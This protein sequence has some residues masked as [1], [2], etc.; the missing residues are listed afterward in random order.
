[1][2]YGL[3]M[4]L[5]YFGTGTVAMAN[6]PAYGTGRT[7]VEPYAFWSD[8]APSVVSGIDVRAEDIDYDTLRKLFRQWR[9][10]NRFYFGDYYPLTPYSRSDDAW[11]AWQFDRPANRDGVVQAFRRS[12]APLDTVRLKLRALDPGSRYVIRDLHGAHLQLTGRRL[13]EEG[14]PLAIGEQPGAPVLFYRATAS[15]RPSAVGRVQT[16]LV[17]AGRGAS[18]P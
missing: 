3:A 9:R 2:T 15:A 14:L 12:R 13:M 17:T 8:A 11:I 1:M 16:P 10:M 6:P 18:C 7:P 5:P 4:W